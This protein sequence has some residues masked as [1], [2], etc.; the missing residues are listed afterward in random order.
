MPFSFDPEFAPLMASMREAM[1]DAPK[2]TTPLEL[3]AMADVGLGMLAESLPAMA[4]LS[5][6]A[7]TV[8]RADGTELPA[9]WVAKDGHT[10]G[11]AALYLHGGRDGVRQRRHLPRRSCAATWSAAGVPMLAVDYRLA[12]EHPHPTPVEDCFAGLEWLHANAA[13]LGVDPARIAVMGDSAGGGL[14]AGV[15]LLARDRGVPLAKQILVFPML[16]DRTTVPDP[17]LVDFA[18]WTYEQN[19]MGW[20]ALL[21]DAI[22]GADVSPYAAPARAADLAGLAPAYLDVGELDIFRD[23]DVEYCRR[24]GARR[25]VG[26]APRAPG[27]RPRLRHDARRRPGHPAR[28]RR[29]VP[30]AHVL[31]RHTA[32]PVGV[33]IH[34]VDLTAPVATADVEQLRDLYREHHLLLFRGAVLTGRRQVEVVDWF[35]PVLAEKFGAFGVISNVVEGSPV[36][37]GGL[38]YHSDFALHAR[39]AARDLVARV[40]GARRRRTD[41]VRRRGPGHARFPPACG[42]SSRAGASSTCSTSARPPTGGCAAADLAPGSPSVSPTCSGCT[43]ITGEEIVQANEMH[44]DCILAVTP[45]QSEALLAE[46]FGHLYAPANVYEHAW[47]AGDLVIWDNLAVHHGRPDFPVHQERTLQRVVLGTKGAAEIVPNLAELLAAAK[48]GT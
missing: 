8:R 23:E 17:E 21:G 20:R 30:Y 31:V 35:G 15:A 28:A 11:S 12:P 38:T 26:G 2:A 22:G 6:R 47:E 3:R 44:T 34:E 32:L 16:D 40:G 33:E 19:E 9:V 36:P 46:L 7:V 14:A 39:P 18:G 25:R 5:E 29:P 13:E 10:T 45:E 24:L 42:P 4:G 27:G 43:R 37:E 1:V 41:P 48:A